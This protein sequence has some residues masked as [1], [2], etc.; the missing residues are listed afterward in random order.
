MP[1]A[2]VRAEEQY[3]NTYFLN[4]NKESIYLSDF[5][6]LSFSAG[7]ILGYAEYLDHSADNNLGYINEL[8]SL[9]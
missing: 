6:Q 7:V 8:N 5:S 2:I 3:G 1:D 9:S 4:N